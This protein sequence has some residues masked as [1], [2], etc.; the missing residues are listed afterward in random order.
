M[1]AAGDKPLSIAAGGQPRVWAHVFKADK[2]AKAMVKEGAQLGAEIMGV[3]SQAAFFGGRVDMPYPGQEMAQGPVPGA[4]AKGAGLKNEAEIGPFNQLQE[5]QGARDR[6]HEIPV[7]GFQ[8]EADAQGSGGIAE[9][10]QAAA[11]ALP[12]LRASIGGAM[13]AGKDANIGGAQL[14]GLGD[15]L[16]ALSQ[17]ISRMGL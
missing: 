5:A 14:G 2:A 16:M 4:G 8:A 10:L 12:L 17:G 15:D 13:I 7:V 1:A 3:A 6:V 11:G 9:F